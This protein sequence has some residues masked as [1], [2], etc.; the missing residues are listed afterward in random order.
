VVKTVFVGTRTT[1]ITDDNITDAKISSSGITTAGKVSG[2]TI[3]SGTINSAVL[4]FYNADNQ[5]LKKRILEQLTK[6]LLSKT[7][8][9]LNG[10]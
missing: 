2:S 10:F 5:L 7:S 9:N 8:F 3:T 1:N 4:K 6:R